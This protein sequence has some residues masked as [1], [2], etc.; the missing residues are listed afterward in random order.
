MDLITSNHAKTTDMDALKAGTANIGK[1]CLVSTIANNL[2]R[3]CKK[4]NL[5]S[6]LNND[7][8]C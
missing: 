4:Q 8:K 1:T 5:V 2:N 7:A 6:L 3:L